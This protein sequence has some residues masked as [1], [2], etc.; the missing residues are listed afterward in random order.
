MDELLE[1]RLAPST[2]PFYYTSCDFFGPY[3]VK[4]GRN[5]TTKY[6]RVIFTG[7]NSKAVRLELAVDC[8]TMEFIQVLRRFF[9]VRGQPSV[10]ISDN[11][12]LREFSAEKGV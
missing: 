3:H 5:K 12:R 1:C 8:L 2:P 10:I 9:S 7:L 6:Y 11:G 4:V